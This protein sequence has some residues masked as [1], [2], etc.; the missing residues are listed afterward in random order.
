MTSI[1]RSNDNREGPTQFELN[2]ITDDAEDIDIRLFKM[3]SDTFSQFMEGKGHSYTPNELEFRASSVAKCSRKIL[4]QKDPKNYLSDEEIEDLGMVDQVSINKHEVKI[5]FG[6]STAGQ[7][8][9]EVLQEVLESKI[10]SMEEEVSY[11]INDV[12]LIGHYDLLVEDELT[13]EKI[14]IDIKTTS[15]KR[16]Y[17][18]NQSHLTQ[19]MA[20][21]GMLKGIRGAILYVN[22]NNFDFTYYPQEFSKVKF[23]D[24]IM[25]VVNLASAERGKKLPPPIPEYPEECANYS[26]KCEFY[27]YCFPANIGFSIIED[28]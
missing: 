24:I 22:R 11:K 15:A 12:T 7:L 27:N 26:F 10:H 17:L 13:G 28:E 3:I 14:V 23:S 16:L 9:H 5:S 18:P 21:Q 8:I 4:L 2:G 20:Y 25:K 6:A 1:N 19:L